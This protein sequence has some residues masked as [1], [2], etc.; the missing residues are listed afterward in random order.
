MTTNP[1][2]VPTP[3]LYS[4]AVSFGGVEPPAGVPPTITDQPDAASV[5]DGATASF[6]VAATG[7]APLTYQWQIL[8]FNWT[9]LVG[10]TAA[11]LNFTAVH[12]DHN[13]KLFRCVVTN[14]VANANS[15]SAALTVTPLVAPVVV[16]SPVN[17]TMNDGATASGL[18]VDFTGS[19][20][21]TYQW[22]RNNGGGYVALTGETTNQFTHTAV[23]AADNGAL[24]KVVATNA[25]GSGESLPFTLTVTPQAPSITL[26][27]VD[28]TVTTFDAQDLFTVAASGTVA[29]SY[30][31]Q[32]FVTGVWSDSVGDTSPTLNTATAP[33][34]AGLLF[35]CVVT[36]A[37]GSVNSAGARLTVD[38]AGAGAVAAPALS[39]QG[40]GIHV[41]GPSIPLDATELVLQVCAD[42]GGVPVQDWSTRATFATGGG[43][44]LDGGS[45]AGNPV[46]VP[47]WYRVVSDAG[48]IS[49]AVSASTVGAPAV[50]DA[51]VMTESGVIG[52]EICSGILVFDSEGKLTIPMTAGTLYTYDL[53]GA[54]TI[55][56][57]DE[58]VTS[59]SSGSYTPTV[60]GDAILETG[61]TGLS[62]LTSGDSIIAEVGLTYSV[63]T[64]A[65]PARAVGPDFSG[66]EIDTGGGYGNYA[67]ASLTPAGFAS[68]GLAVNFGDSA[69]VRFNAE[70]LYGTSFGTP[71][72]ATP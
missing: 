8:L 69:T 26:Q 49:T 20:P 1:Q 33:S 21:K 61:D 2:C 3:S 58:N 57:P 68:P 44:H 60:T 59:D 67:A 23:Y 7:T 63:E 29:L 4:G 34:L 53:G 24:F 5:N 15:N 51:P 47:F 66:A 25:A 55:T 43:T 50:A 65:L 28:K 41:T 9:N 31:W 42:S 10:E 18:F 11:T 54:Y 13:G 17:Q 72:T 27:P 45:G 36:N 48:G 22:W 6:T 39:P 38:K 35:R 64:P 52:T 56:W 70:N 71:A 37:Y 19:D 46:P 62:G 30:Q 16:A 32:V 12:A 14:A 40:D